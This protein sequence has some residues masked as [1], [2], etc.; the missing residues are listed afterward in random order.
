MYV[1]KII[2]HFAS[3]TFHC[4]QIGYPVIIN[5]SSVSSFIFKIQFELIL[6]FSINKNIILQ[7]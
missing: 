4:Q 1:I 7:G 3:V 2:Q 6:Q 5:R